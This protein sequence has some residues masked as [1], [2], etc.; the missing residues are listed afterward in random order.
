M[1]RGISAALRVA[2][3]VADALL[4]AG[5]LESEPGRLVT[6]PGLADGNLRLNTKHGAWPDW[7][8]GP[9]RP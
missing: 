3:A 6:G 9:D 1:R 5:W 2:Q 7:L 8:A 4:R